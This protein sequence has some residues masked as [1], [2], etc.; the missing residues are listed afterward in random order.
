MQIALGGDFR[1]AHPQASMSIMEAKWGLIPDMGGNMVLKQLLPVDRAL[2]LTMSAKQFTGTQA[3]DLNLVTQ[4]SETPIEAARSFAHQLV[5]TSPDVLAATKKL[6]LNNWHES[7]GNMLKKETW[8]QLKI[9]SSVNQSIA[10]KRANGK[11]AAFSK[12]TFK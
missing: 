12:R 10:V 5:Q 9:L 2:E 11:D 4:V 7:D 1:I 6:Y 3:Y 8:Y